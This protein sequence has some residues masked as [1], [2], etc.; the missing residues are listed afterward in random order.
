MRVL[1]T[2]IMIGGLMA[3]ATGAS[4]NPYLQESPGFAG[5]SASA[6]TSPQ[7][8][9]TRLGN[10]SYTCS[11]VSSFGSNFTD[12]FTFTSPG[13]ISSDFDLFAAELGVSLGCACRPSGSVTH[14]KF[15]ASFGFECVGP[16][17]E[18]SDQI[19]IAGTATA[20][21]ITKGQATNSHGDTFLFTCVKN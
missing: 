13:A 6:A 20:T 14:P 12:T 1:L 7:N 5:A 9:Q 16:I 17:P 3:P 18:S 10:N 19:A 8:C 21:K 15:E 11:V 2:I 4:A